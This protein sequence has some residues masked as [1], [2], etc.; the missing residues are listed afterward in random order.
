MSRYCSS[1]CNACKS[2]SPVGYSQGWKD[3]FFFFFL[4]ATTIRS[5]MVSFHK[6]GIA[7]VDGEIKMDG[8]QHEV[9]VR[10]RYPTNILH[11]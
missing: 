9:R 10:S 5:E 3:F 8:G 2:K 6:V 11:R 4:G 7:L 1:I